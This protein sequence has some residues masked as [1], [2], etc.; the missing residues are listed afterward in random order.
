MHLLWFQCSQNVY[1]CLDMPK[2]SQVF[3]QLLCRLWRTKCSRILVG[4]NKPSTTNL[5]MKATI[6]PTTPP[7]RDCAGFCSSANHASIFG[8]YVF[9]VICSFDVLP[10]LVDEHGKEWF[11]D[12]CRPFWSFFYNATVTQWAKSVSLSQARSNQASKLHECLIIQT[13]FCI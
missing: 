7:C 10:C 4:R 9:F 8:Q 6:P 11:R 1:V 12:V 13:V 5:E 2:T 3:V